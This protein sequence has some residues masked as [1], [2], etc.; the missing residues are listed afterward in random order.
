LNGHILAKLEYLNPGFSKKDQIAK[1]II[2]DA[3]ESGKLQPGQT[4]VE[5]TSGNTAM[6]LAIVC[7]VWGY[8]FVGVMSVGNSM[9]QACMMKAL[10]V[11]VVMVDQESGSI[12]GQV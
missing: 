5:L 4:V 8:P 6:G 9:E 7:G 2:V 11:K 10:G 1:Q 12:P 3:K